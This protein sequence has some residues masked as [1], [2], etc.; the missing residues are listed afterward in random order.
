MFA[1]QYWLKHGAYFYLYP[2]QSGDNL[3]ARGF[4]D[5][6]SQLADR[7][8]AVA[9]RSKAWVCGRSVTGIVG[10]NPAGGMDVCLLGVL[11]VVR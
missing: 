4:I 9:A 2:R 3:Q 10:L 6:S 5:T 1:M 8:I 11:C 7:P